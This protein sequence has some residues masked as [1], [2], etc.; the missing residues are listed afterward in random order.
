MMSTSQPEQDASSQGDAVRRNIEYYDR[1]ARE[2]FARHEQPI[3]R[4]TTR[5]EAKWI[6]QEVPPKSQVLLAGSGGGREIAPLLDA[7]C[8]IVALD[9]SPS[10]VEIG[11]RAWSDPNVRFVL[12]DVHDPASVGGPYDVIMSL[13][14]VNYF[15]DP[16]KAI[17]TLADSLRPGGRMIVSCINRLHPTERRSAGSDQRRTFSPA[18]LGDMFEAAG[19]KSI[20]ARGFRLFA[21]R[22]PAAWNRVGVSGPRRWTV[23]ASL[24]VERAV[25]PLMSARSGKFFWLIGTRA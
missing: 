4:F 17:R 6:A 7:G 11:R 19:L 23:E 12:G 15:S 9:Y 20:R 10:M 22:L 14:A 21:D 25:T 13:A 1:I 16:N 5:L 18:E 2:Y 24:L 8:S 3:Q